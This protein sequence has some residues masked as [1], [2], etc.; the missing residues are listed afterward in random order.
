MNRK[1]IVI[2]G[3]T[4]FIGRYLIAELTRQNRPVRVVTRH[5]E[6]HRNLLVNPLVRLVEADIHQ[7][8]S[9]AQVLSDA[10]VVINLVGTL[11]GT[12]ET[13]QRVHFELAER[14]VQQ[15]NRLKVKRL[16]HLS[17]L[18]SG[19]ANALSNY[20]RSKHEGENCIH[21]LSSNHLQVTSFRPSVIF[22]EGDH[23]FTTFA[24]LLRLP[25]LVVPLA[26]PEARFAPIHVV[27]VAHII[28]SA[29]DDPATYGK[30]YNL[31]GPR[32]YN[33]LELVEITERALGVRR[34]IVGLNERLSRFS[35]RILGL[36]PGRL[37]LLT[38]DNL[39]TM[40]LDSTCKEAPPAPINFERTPLEGVITHYIG[41]RNR[42]VRYDHYRT[43]AGR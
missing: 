21:L 24:A 3:G 41:D 10:D 16:L 22:G 25:L 14:L 15:C 32:E 20:L 26:A 33:L 31:C 9:L 29:I 27:D 42:Q 8:E 17:A 37:K 38:P 36:L 23:F 30:R 5:R 1:E 19:D 2:L 4:G 7:E 39:L 28:A 18:R 40:Q 12:P 35:A 34:L 13:F 6:R 43:R 11:H